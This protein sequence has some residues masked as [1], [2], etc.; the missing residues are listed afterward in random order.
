MIAEDINEEI[1]KNVGGKLNNNL[2]EILRSFTD[3][4]FEIQTFSDIESMENKLKPHINSFSIVSLNI[5]SINAK[6]D[7][8]TTLIDYLKESDF[9]FSAICIQETWLKKIRIHHC[10]KYQVINLYIKVKS[11]VSMED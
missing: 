11:V 5:Q 8:L 10:F 3:T 2:N 9:M 4:D 1:L 6:F 7:K